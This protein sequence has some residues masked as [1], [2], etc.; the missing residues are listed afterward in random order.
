MSRALLAS[1]FLAIDWG[2]T[3]RSVY[4]LDP[5]GSSILL[6]TGDGASLL[7]PAGYPQIVADIRERH[8]RIP[9]LIAGMAGSDRGW[10]SVPYAAC[11][12]DIAKLAA[13]V[14]WVE[15]DT[16]ILPGVSIE[17]D[18]RADV[19]RGEEVQVLGAIA[20]GM[21]PDQ[22]TICQPGTHSKWIETR[23]ESI[24]AFRT[25]MT[26]EIFALLKAKSSLS[27]ALT[28]LPMPGPAFAEGVRRSLQAQDLLGDLFALRAD[29]LL[30]RVPVEHLASRASGL[31]IGADIAA[32]TRT[33]STVYLL[34]SNGSLRHLYAF[35]LGIAG[36]E[37]EIIELSPAFAAGIRAVGAHL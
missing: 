31:L 32:H 8:G 7:E 13:T 12:V 9:V 4:R 2:T 18:G 35:A 14:I 6:E 29:L 24:E 25:A 22:A 30:D 26:G 5:D 17:T 28:A 16:A 1:P 23:G 21:V 11:P 15:H 10:R 33:G 37:V 19:M 36:I 3:T 20:A 27:S 34:A